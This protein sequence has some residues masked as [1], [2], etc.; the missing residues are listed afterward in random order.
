MKK[1]VL[2]N[3][4]ISG[5]CGSV[6]LDAFDRLIKEKGFEFVEE[7]RDEEA[8]V[9][10]SKVWDRK[11]INNL[12]DIAFALILSGGKK[13]SEGKTKPRSLRKLPHHTKAVKSPT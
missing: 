2:V 5:A 1:R 8:N 12:P 11:Y 9:S 3:A 7:L 13:D 4:G 6:V 10:F